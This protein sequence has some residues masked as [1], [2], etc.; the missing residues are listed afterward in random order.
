MITIQC[1]EEA[2]DALSLEV[3]VR[4]RALGLV[5]HLRK[6][7]CN[8]RHSMGLH[9]PVMSYGTHNR[10]I[11]ICVYIYTRVYMYIY[12]YTI[13]RLYDTHMGWLRLVGSLKLQVSFAEYS[14]YYRFFLQKRPIILRSLLIVATPYAKKRRM[15]ETFCCARHLGRALCVSKETCKRDLCMLK[16]PC[17]RD[18]QRTY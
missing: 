7:I 12:T 5:A 6:E 14:L 11:Y 4:K 13:E 15:F 8:L 3:I 10:V 2:Q 18:L 9:H 1:G 16:E 17:K